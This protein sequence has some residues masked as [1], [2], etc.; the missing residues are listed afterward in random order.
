MR[1]RLF[2]VFSGIICCSTAA[3]CQVSTGNIVGQITDA[4]GTLVP[5]V[6][7][8][9]RHGDTAVSVTVEADDS[10][11]YSAP[12]L[13]AGMYDISA[14][15]AGFRSETL[16][17]V[18]LLAQQTVRL[19]FQLVVASVQQSIEVKAQAQL[20]QTDS[21]TIN[22]SINE[23]QLTDLPTT[24]RSIDGLMILAPGVTGFGSVSNI[25]NPQISGSHYWGSTNF[26]LNVARTDT[27]RTK[28]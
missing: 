9:I 24:S 21:Q 8:V 15:K 3:L 12:N 19:D 5:R 23:R 18:Q 4:S 17:A 6:E 26:S 2:S 16:T 1:R 10:G 11:A 25:S 20:V 13:L 22:S 7:I 27:S 28:S 14:R